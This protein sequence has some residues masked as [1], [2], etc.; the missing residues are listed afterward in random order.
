MPIKTPRFKASRSLLPRVNL[1][2]ALGAALTGVICLAVGFSGYL[3]PGGG[4]KIDL[5]A[6]LM[7]PFTDPSHILGTD[8]LGRDVLARVVAGGRISLLVG[9]V[10]VF[11]SVFIGTGLGLVAG[12]YRGLW[13]MALMRFVD[14]QLA[15]PFILLAI[16]VMAIF[17]GGLVNTILLLIL[18]QC[19]YYVRL[20]RGLTLS[21]R[22]REF[23][24]S[25][26]AIGVTD[27]RIILQHVLPN[28][29]GPVIVLM[30]LS[31]A[32][33]ILLES[34]LTFLGLGV[35]PTIPSWGGM[36]ADGR[37]YLQSAWWVSLFPGLAI[38]LAVLGLNLLGD[39]LRD[40]L[41]PT[42]RSVR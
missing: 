17:G 20:V 41:D 40:T 22:E 29:L 27:W 26:R 24:L 42:D 15:M 19:V 9:F 38:L 25:A 10:S 28:L 33:N 36:L 3:F 7:P 8:P 31:V 32:S 37:T 11:G 6:R 35:D 12:Y 5:L 34:S 16:T 1:E 30:T 14:V 4:N 21:L 13:D 23:V 2:L 18:A 39:W